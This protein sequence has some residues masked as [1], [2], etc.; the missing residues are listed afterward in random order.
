MTNRFSIRRILFLT[1]LC[2]IAV[3]TIL[4]TSSAAVATNYT[5][6]PVA[7]TYV[8]A[9]SP[10]AN[11]GTSSLIWMDATPEQ[12]GYVR[13]DVQ[14]LD[15]PVTSAT[16]RLFMGS[17]NTTGFDVHAVADN[18]WNETA[19]TY[20]NAPT[21]GSVINTSGVVTT[22]SWTEID[23]TNY[24][25]GDGLYSFGLT[26][27]SGNP[28]RFRTKDSPNS[29]ELLIETAAG[30]TP[31]STPTAT[32][33]ATPTPTATDGPTAT[34][35]NTATATASIT[36]TATASLTPLPGG[37][38]T[39]TFNPVADAAVLSN[40]STTNYGFIQ[41]LIAD[42][43]PEITSYLQ[44]DVQGLDGPVVSATLRLYSLETS[45]TGIDV[46]EVADNSWQENSITYD[47]APALGSTI[48]SS[49]VVSADAWT[50]IDITS[51]ISEEGLVNLS[52]STTDPS[53]RLTFASREAANSPELIVQTGGGPTPTL[54]PTPTDT[55]TATPTWTPS[56]TPTSDEF[57][58]DLEIFNDSPTMPGD[59]TL[60][61]ASITGGTNVV[62]SWD[63][64]DGTVEDS[65]SKSSVGHI[66]TVAGTYTA[67]LT[68]S[69]SVSQLSA[70][71]L[72]TITEEIDNGPPVWWNDDFTY[73]RPLTMTPS[74]PIIYDI[75][76]NTVTA[77]ISD[78]DLLINEGKLQ[79]NGQDLR[80][81]F[82]NGENWS[83][84]PTQTS[85]VISPTATITFALQAPLTKS[86]T[87][88]WLYYGNAVVP[89]PPK[90]TAPALT[91][92]HIITEVIGSSVVTPTVL[93]SADVRQVWL[94][95][96]VTFTS[97][98]APSA[99]SHIWS[100]G[101]G[102]T[103]T[104][105]LT[106]TSH[107]YEAP[108]L[109]E[110]TL[111][112]VTTD[113]MEVT[114]GYT[115]Y[116]SVL[117][118][119]DDD[120]A[121]E[122][123]LEETV[124]VTNTVVAGAGEQ[125][126]VSA[127]GDLQLTFPETAITQTLIVEHVPFQAAVAQN[128]GNLNRF[129]VSATSEL[130]GEPVTQFA[131]PVTLELDIEQYD[132]TEDE[133]DSILFFYWNEDEGLWQ[134]VATTVDFAQ[135]KVWAE[136][137]N[138]TEFAVATN[139]GMGTPPLRRLPS[140]SGGGVD[141]ITGA[142]TYQYPL[143]V[144][145]GTH[146]VQPNLSLVYNSGAADT[147]LDQQAGLVGHGFELAGLGWIQ[148]DVD[149]GDYYLNLNGVSEKLIQEGS[150]TS[151]Y[152][153][154]P[155]YWKISFLD[156]GDNGVDSKYWLVT[157]QDGT[158][159]R[160]GFTLKSASSLP[161][162]A[163]SPSQAYRYELE[164]I[165]DSYGNT[166]NITYDQHVYV[167]YD[168][169]TEITASSVSWPIS[170][171][172]TS[173][174]VATTLG[175]REI[176]FIYGQPDPATTNSFGWR[177]DYA[178]PFTMHDVGP[179]GEYG[180]RDA[181]MSIEMY[182]GGERIR[183]YLFNYEYYTQGGGTPF[184][185]GPEKYHLMLRGMQEYG[186]SETSYLPKTV[187]N[188]AE[189]GHLQVVT[190]GYGGS[191]TYGYEKIEAWMAATRVYHNYL[192]SIEGEEPDTDRWRVRTRAIYDAVSQEVFVTSYNYG[193]SIFVEGSFKG[194]Q[195]INITTPENESTTTYHSLGSYYSYPNGRD[196]AYSALIGQP[197]R[198]LNELSTTTFN[199]VLDGNGT[200][201]VRCSET[202]MG[203]TAPVL[204]TCYS[205]DEYGNVSR[206][207]EN[208]ER[209]TAIEYL[210]PTASQLN[211][212]LPTIVK[213][214]NNGGSVLVSQTDYD[215][216][217]YTNSSAIE[218]V[219]VTKP[220][221]S[222]AGGPAFITYSHFDL[223]GNVDESWVGSDLYA[224]SIQYDPTYQTFPDVVSYPDGSQMTFDYDARFG[225]AMR[226]GDMRGA[227]TYY[228]YDDFGRP[229]LIT[230]ENNFVSYTY[231]DDSISEAVNGLTVN[232]N[233]FGRTDYLVQS[234]NGLGQLYQE[235]LEGNKTGYA[236]DSQGRPI[237]HTLPYTDDSNRRELLTT[238][239]AL[240]R[241][242]TVETRDS[243]DDQFGTDH[244]KYAYPDWQTVIATDAQGIPTEYRLDAFGR[245]TAVM[246]GGTTTTQY[247]YLDNTSDLRLQIVDDAGNQT[248]ITYDS[249]GRK[250]SLVD[251]N[252]GTWL[253]SYDQRGNLE[254]QTDARGVVTTMAYDVLG[255]LTT[256]SYT[257]P[258]G[259]DIAETAPVSFEYPNH[260]RTEMWDGSGHT[261][262]QYDPT[263]LLLQET[264]T[265]DGST[266]TTSYGYNFGRLQTITY[267]DGEVITYTFGTAN[268]IIGLVGEDT[269]LANATYDALG[270]VQLWDLGG[271]AT[272]LI[273]YNATTFRPAFVETTNVNSEVVQDLELFFDKVGRLDWWTDNSQATSLWLNPT[274][275]GL[276]R[277]DSIDS[278][279]AA[280][281]QNY[282]YDAVGNLTDRN[283][284]AF[285]YGLGERPHLPGTDS[286]GTEYE[287]DENGN[288]VSRLFVDNTIVN[289]TYDAE[290]RLTQVV[291]DTVD[292]V[293]TTTLTY[294]G[295]GQLVLQNSGEA[296][297][298]LFV[299]EFM[300]G[301]SSDSSGANLSNS[302]EWSEMP[303]IAMNGDIPYFVW[304]EE[305]DILFYR[306]D[307][308]AITS[309]VTIVE[310]TTTANENLTHSY[311]SITIGT[312]GTIHV[313]W[314][315]YLSQ[316][317]PY[318][319]LGSDVYYS[320]SQDG[321]A[322]W[323][324]PEA[325]SEAFDIRDY[326]TGPDLWDYL[327]NAKA[328]VVTDNENNVHVMWTH[329]WKPDR[330][331]N[332]PFGLKTLHRVRLAS[333]SWG[334][335][336]LILG[337]SDL[338]SGWVEHNMINGAANAVYA[339]LH[340]TD[341]DSSLTHYRI[342]EDGFWGAS[343]EYVGTVS[344]TA[345]DELG[346][347]HTLLFDHGSVPVSYLY[348]TSEAATWSEPEQVGDGFLEGAKLVVSGD[349]V[350]N[351]VY[352]IYEDETSPAPYS[353]YYTVRLTENEWTSARNVYAAPSF[354]WPN[355]HLVAQ[356]D[357]LHFVYEYYDW[358]YQDVLYAHTGSFALEDVVK[359]YFVGGQQ[360]ATRTGNGALYYHLNDPSGTS[361]LLLDENGDEAGQM[362][363]DA[364]GGVLTSTMPL[365]VSDALP[366][367]PDA[368]T[369]LVH[370]G[371]G[372]WYDPAL[373]RPLQPNPA[374]GPPT[375]PQALNRYTATP[376]GQPG[377]FQAAQTN[378]V[379]QIIQ[380]SFNQVPGLLAGPPTTAVAL[381][382]WAQTIYK[383]IPSGFGVVQLQGTVRSLRF[384][385]DSFTTVSTRLADGWFSRPF[386]FFFK[387][388]RMR[389]AIGRAYIGD[390][391]DEIIQFQARLGQRGITA[392]LLSREFDEV[393]DVAATSA[394]RSVAKGLGEVIG[395]GIG[396]L[397]NA[398][399][400]F[401]Y[402]YDNP[403]LTGS[404][405]FQRAGVSGIA[406]G[407]A[408]GI[409]LAAAGVWG[410]P[411][412]LGVAFTLGVV[413][414]LE[415]VPWV[416][417]K[418][419][420][421]PTRNLS[422]LASP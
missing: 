182:V 132:L 170:I 10:T 172:Y 341:S 273:Q 386:S 361:L 196:Y 175:M 39:F 418:I 327:L 120:V 18:S 347:I 125:T 231:S 283:G 188:Y 232:I 408:G 26:T 374:G 254:T 142:A 193:G 122:L 9:D 251:P 42:S 199:Y 130:T 156:G 21:M 177:A 368:V 158:Q 155:T 89:K 148:L 174:D 309:P 126:V 144:P 306:L 369:G 211:S 153:E 297:S 296:Q 33:T 219:T 67:T 41:T 74:V 102:I 393:I 319:Y 136:T 350:V 168:F 1:V 115:D 44:F 235:D 357:T 247:N 419:G 398:G 269:Y 383:S 222:S 313:V 340:E 28:I 2:I 257:I 46:K 349:G 190:N 127:Q 413:L 355:A 276:N 400:Q 330:D 77:T 380:S 407:V 252:M 213:Q 274:Y 195:Q 262:W 97:E 416:F 71:T 75:V 237:M 85:S 266:F 160:F 181:L 93:F 105:T 11:F 135:G 422:T 378:P 244:I 80:I 332:S 356:G 388:S 121:I 141:L 154:H 343:Q 94:T 95:E 302:S 183:T 414:E 99:D 323:G 112:A 56:P 359:N 290:N 406:G 293:I 375:V 23:V 36:P 370:L 404:Q 284:L 318:E 281:Q 6:F 334:D 7:D 100:F 298:K 223:L 73:R 184:G 272:Q 221:L 128:S 210:P 91:E 265:I 138:I 301:T 212:T 245:I 164:Q 405:K 351:L 358:T 145:P 271:V 52:F 131:Q 48:N 139:Y 185:Y 316:V 308:P 107:T 200:V 367:V 395:V 14:N 344:E 22:N 24:I 176:Q 236:Y 143:Q 152:T 324:A 420:A 101:D 3:F 111:T 253:Y 279:D 403:Y 381:H 79:E 300:Q 209:I 415:V 241:P 30:A 201:V 32:N 20:N 124:I 59:S 63:F 382:L 202:V 348:K 362:V 391:A 229:E 267:P 336:I 226:T 113:T 54:T 397:F 270:Q 373:G 55:A 364:F 328:H 305:G 218:S 320:Y 260:T 70:S 108:G 178:G 417:E 282:E 325:V 133:A 40:R 387:G 68:A 377:V 25:T 58:T 220:D 321:G 171:E 402:D 187:L 49:G 280:F 372:R 38:S 103:V 409:G 329:N 189:T 230:G 228:D 363:Y 27:T 57:I 399:I 379:G 53:V 191:V 78:T 159:Y 315:S 224:T 8:D 69:N 263:G 150:S 162:S 412:G 207:D 250:V 278:N 392:R 214:F 66:F 326:E 109:Y 217:F 248:M 285:T 352:F 286:E 205:Y 157:T 411:V 116:I 275:D 206:I 233:S 337:E 64:G 83:L 333:G 197:Y 37:G 151:Y 45:S 87:S 208:N 401:A 165:Q 90:L 338:G 35:T 261:V 123:G 12:R 129:D 86:N 366:G 140:I 114:F 360:V 312:D 72:I 258:E 384:L 335:D 47:S 295:N 234:Y 31:T 5:F 204:Q 92:S 76:N 15:S 110:V 390:T 385:D 243:T 394:S 62:Y 277:L 149:T 96:A 289:Y 314:N 50:D 194:H 287:Y 179:G 294:D 311:P 161:H 216:V 396:G 192:G 227:Q 173:N 331:P 307:D 186:A 169:M 249:L 255:R 376:L 317:S 292:S 291:S 98:V 299:N 288:L 147:L 410:G 259:L 354:S 242:L 84:V 167:V 106:Q 304:A 371:R 264:K 310:E 215:Y 198:S 268:Q 166:I 256:K 88:Y 239:D 19:V 61:W 389:T 119:R 342:W 118:A 146:G 339:F 421:I 81:T 60:L 345:I 82:W 137:D 65:G 117:Q 180:P 225:L 104:E 163:S 346:T 43:S 353:M 240:G 365:A 13:F 29:P 134:P 17:N 34:P 246:E 4:T 322:S 303:S 238:Y 51:Y 16:L 203:A